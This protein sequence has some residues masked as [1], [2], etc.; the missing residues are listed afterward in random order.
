[1]T[2][3]RDRLKLALSETPAEGE[4]SAAE[5]AERINALKSAQAVEAAPV[6]MKAPKTRMELIRKRAVSSQELPSAS[7]PVTPQVSQAEDEKPE[8]EDPSP[9]PSPF[10][11][12]VRRRGGQQTLF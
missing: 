3:L 6:R 12:Q 10:R 1:L 5:L 11:V 4:P 9:S 2:S 8:E 7:K